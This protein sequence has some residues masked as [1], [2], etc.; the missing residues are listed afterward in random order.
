MEEKNKEEKLDVT[1]KRR[2]SNKFNFVSEEEVTEKKDIVKN[3]FVL[4][5]DIEQEEKVNEE[6]TEKVISKDISEEKVKQFNE[7][8]DDLEKN[9]S[10]TIEK[11]TL[12]T[13]EKKLP[14]SKTIKESLSI[15]VNNVNNEDNEQ[16]KKKMYFSFE[17]RVIVSIILIVSLF[18]TSCFFAYEAVKYSANPV[19]SYNEESKSSYEVCVEGE[20]F[21]NKSCL[22]EGMQYIS[23]ITNNIKAKFNYDVSFSKDINYDLKYY[24]VAVTKIYDKSNPTL[25]LYNKEDVL[26]A[27][28]SLKKTDSKI[29][30][31][32]NVEI[33]YKNYKNFIDSY[34]NV[35]SIE[36]D[37]SLDVILYLDEDEKE[38]RAI[39]SLNIPLN[40]DLYT[41][42]KKNTSNLNR[43]VE[44]E[45]DS[46]NKF[47]MFCTIGAAFL[48]ILALVLI[49]RLTN[50]VLRAYKC[51]NIYQRELTKILRE[52]DR[53]IVVA[54][55]GYETLEVKRMI[56]V[57]SFKELLD[58]RDVLGKPII[59]VKVNNVKSEFYVEDDDKVYLYVMKD[60]D[61]TGK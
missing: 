23:S 35:Y 37:S 1:E 55:S 2:S 25:V 8:A 13:E 60:A 47:S 15:D 21:Y 3:K 26:V 38:D 32:E 58:A 43:N 56:K 59:Y 14:E 36:A 52:Y 44:I 18:G 6:K 20:D 29:T 11:V 33:P 9:E 39:A 5:S 49:I 19:V 16:N 54:R 17:F 53:V 48:A 57:T 34:N 50:L 7:K 22:K 45:S 40:T 41:I 24:I 12:S 42:T 46:Y 27:P 10:D 4:A 28:K 51:K 31:S 30:L 61:F